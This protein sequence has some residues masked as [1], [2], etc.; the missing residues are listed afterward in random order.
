MFTD[1][2]MAAAVQQSPKLGLQVSGTKF[3]LGGVERRGIGLNHFSLLLRQLDTTLG[4]AVDYTADMTTIKQSYGL[5][6]VRF[7]AGWHSRSAWY[8]KWY[9]AKSA[10]FAAFDAIVAKAEQL[11]LGLIP[12]LFWDLRGFSNIVYDVHGSY[13][14]PNTLATSTSQAWA[15]AAEFITDVVGR[16]RASPAIWGWELGNESV[17]SIGPEYYSTWLL[18]GTGVDGVGTALPSTLNWGAKP[19]GG[20]YAAAD[21]FSMAQWQEFTRRAVRLIHT[22]D[23][24]GRFVASGAGHGNS[25]AVKAQTTNT[26]SADTLAEWNSINAQS[27]FAYRDQA[28]PVLSTHLYPQNLSNGRFFSGAEKTAG[29]LITLHKGWADAANKPFFLGEFGAS[30]LVAGSPDEISTDTASE[31]T[32]FNEALAAVV[33]SGVKLSAVWNYGGNLAGSDAWQLWKLADPA[34][35]YQLTAIAAAN[36]AMQ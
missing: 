18:D 28:F 24:Y 13:A 34:R 27:W 9:L 10:Y 25:F 2:L 7:A 32:N 19:G 29:E 12:T 35:V 14:A 5:P 11:G 21:K 22:T 36:A 26:I 15:L 8:N 17:G 6:F 20:N 1:P 31:T 16:Y 30:Y 3:I 33:S 4:P 23:G